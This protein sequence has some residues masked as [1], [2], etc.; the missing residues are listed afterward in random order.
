MKYKKQTRSTIIAVI[1]MLFQSAS[2]APKAV[3]ATP[4]VSN[5]KVGLLFGS[6]AA[7]SI[8][9][10]NVKDSGNGFEFGY[11]DNNR[12]FVTLGVSTGASKISVLRDKNM[13]YNKVENRYD[14][15]IG[16]AVVIGCYHIQLNNSVQDYYSAIA[17]ANQFENSFIKYFNGV[18]Y[19][20][21][22]NY[23]TYD[24][25]FAEMRARGITNASVNSGTSYTLTVAITG[26]NTILF[27]FD[28]ATVQYLAVQPI[29]SDGVSKCVT[30]CKKY[31]YCGGFQFG[32]PQGE[33]IT[34]LNVVNIE[35]YTRGVIPY[36]MNNTWPKEALKAQALCARTYAASSLNAH[37]STGFDLCTTEH[38]QVYLGLNH[39]NELTDSCVN[40]TLGQYITYNGELCTTYFSSSS[41][42]AT[43]NVENVW[44]ETIPY[45]RGVLDIYEADIATIAPDY[46]WKVTYTPEQLAARL[47]TKGYQCGSSIRSLQIT[48]FSAMGNVNQV[49]FVDNKGKTI[50]IQKGDAIRSALGVGSIHFTVGNQTAPAFDGSIYVNDPNSNIDSGLSSLYII[51]GNGNIEGISAGNSFAITGSGE[52][53]RL[54]ESAVSV[55]DDNGLTDGK[56]ILRGAGHGHNIGLSQWGAYSMAKFHNMTYDEI[57]RFYYTGVTISGSVGLD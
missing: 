37:A 22:G 45:L 20:M 55:P 25:A 56:F 13:S 38:C 54:V 7:P 6:S 24:G 49:T 2:A 57:I 17:I 42:G 23:T 43:E 8:N 11:F 1:L 16:G 52:T 28:Y 18:F 39:A 51:D 15:G 27:E 4:L 12:N 53:E 21:I 41:G 40:E 29:S 36:E 48:Q 34:V 32:R 26:T 30:W 9:L 10:Q 46:Y 3:A 33:D 31:Q 5:L 14:A 44:S 50:S 35:D 47:N 19:I